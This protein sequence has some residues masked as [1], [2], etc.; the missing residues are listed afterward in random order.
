MARSCE[1]KKEQGNDEIKKKNYEK[2]I[3]IY[4]DALKID[5]LNKKLNSVVY[6]NRALGTSSKFLQVDLL[7]LKTRAGSRSK[8]ICFF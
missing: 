7:R 3:E 8:L 6:S 1:Q 4:S 2:A 5:P